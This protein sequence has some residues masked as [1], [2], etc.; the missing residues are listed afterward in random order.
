MEPLQRRGAA[1]GALLTPLKKK[2]KKS[3]FSWLSW[4]LFSGLETRVGQLSLP[5][6]AQAHL[7]ANFGTVAASPRSPR[8]GSLALAVAPCVWEDCAEC[9]S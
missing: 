8:C 6:G 9:E 3:L 4:G 5:P 7:E 2:K 1:V